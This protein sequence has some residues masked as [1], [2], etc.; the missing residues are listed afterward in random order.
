MEEQGMNLEVKMPYPFPKIA[1][2]SVRTDMIMVEVQPI[3]LEIRIIQSLVL[4]TLNEPFFWPVSTSTLKP[5]NPPSTKTPSSGNGGTP[6]SMVTNVDPPS[7]S[8]TTPGL[9]T[10]A[11]VGMVA[12]VVVGVVVIAIAFLNYRIKFQQQR[13][14]PPL[15]AADETPIMA[16]VVVVVP[17]AQPVQDRTL[18]ANVLVDPADPAAMAP[19]ADAPVSA[20]ASFEKLPRYKDQIRAVEPPGPI[21][22]MHSSGLDSKRKFQQ[23]NHVHHER[24]DPEPKEHRQ[25]FL[26]STGSKSLPFTAAYF[27]SITIK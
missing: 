3:C 13:I 20:R 18:E 6:N 7:N 17:R 27:L 15:H 24:E 4:R 2:P 8:P 23:R 10:G 21:S 11:I 25:L 19:S 1:S 5:I 9:S 16:D 22:N 26:R 12:I 14:L